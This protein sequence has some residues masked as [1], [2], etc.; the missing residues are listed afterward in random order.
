MSDPQRRYRLHLE[1]KSRQAPA[2]HL[3]PAAWRDASLRHPELAQLLDVSFGWNGERFSAPLDDVDFLLASRFP[4][5]AVNDA[6]RLRWIHTT[7]AGVDQL[8]PLDRLRSD[9]ILTNS[10]GIHIDKAGE[11]AQMALLMLNA[12]LPAVLRAQQQHRWDARLTAPI[13]GKTVLLVG[14]GDLGQ[15]ASRA[16]AALGLRVV[17]LNRSGRAPASLPPGTPG[18]PDVLAPVSELDVWLPEADF[19]I[20]TA[21][22]TP[23]TRGL[24][25]AD[26]LATMRAGASVVNLSR[27]S[28]I[29]YP[30]LFERLRAGTCGG[31]V[32]DV[33]DPE[34]LPGDSAVWDVPGL[35]VTPHI[36]C[37]APDYNQRVLDAWFGNFARWLRGE[38]LANVVSREHGY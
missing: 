20:V 16:A 3:V 6:R 36:S 1:S 38:Q 37:D 7:G 31:A 34:P 23:A 17:A 14:L 26:R 15:A 19:V 32:L 24:L 8:W 12:Q 9:L 5:D 27:A 28:L 13:R 10:S 18:A 21:P 29:D 35:I 4:H 33:F 2:F 30:A 22:L 11:F 25:S